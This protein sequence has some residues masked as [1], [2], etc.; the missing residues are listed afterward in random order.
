MPH[1][2]DKR[3]GSATRTFQ[4]TAGMRAK[5]LSRPVRLGPSVD[6]GEPPRLTLTN[7]IPPQANALAN[8]RIA[9]SRGRR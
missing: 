5:V 1:T 2:A 7:G 4:G 9:N 6:N 8:R 3:T